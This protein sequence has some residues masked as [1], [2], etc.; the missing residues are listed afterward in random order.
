MAHFQAGLRTSLALQDRLLLSIAAQTAVAFVAL[1]TAPDTQ[2]RLLGAADALVQATGTA[3]LWDRS[4]G[5]QEMVELR[6]R[7]ARGE[8][9]GVVAYR[10][11]RMLSFGEVAAL[12]LHVVEEA[13][14]ELPSVEPARETASATAGNP[15]PPNPSPNPLTEREREVLRLVAQGLSSKLIARQ[16][17]IAPGTVNYHLSTAF[18]KLGVDTRAQAVAVATQ[19]GLL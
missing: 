5:F 13:T 3:M 2:A 16:L 9:D 11:G 17:S 14:R 8:G 19:H 12:A 6:E 7:L 1:E 18:N 10:E 4:P 15:S